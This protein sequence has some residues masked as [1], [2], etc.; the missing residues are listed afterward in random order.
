MSKGLSP[1]ATA[2]DPEILQNMIL[3]ISMQ[4]KKEEER[5]LISVY[6]LPEPMIQVLSLFGRWK[7][8]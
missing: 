6:I 5:V 1:N 3:L 4:N 2:V 8:Q 7:P